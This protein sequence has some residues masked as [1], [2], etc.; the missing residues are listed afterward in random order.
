MEQ[1]IE[2][3]INM[4]ILNFSSTIEQRYNINKINLFLYHKWGGIIKDT[5][6]QEHE[7]YYILDDNNKKYVKLDK[8]WNIIVL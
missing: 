5:I 8:D 4:E 2:N 7:I 3:L 6:I 1:E